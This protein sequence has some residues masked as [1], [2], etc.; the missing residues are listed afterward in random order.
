VADLEGAAHP[1]RGRHFAVARPEGRAHRLLDDE[2]QAPGGEQGFERAAIQEA[3]DAAFDH[4][5]DEA[6]D[7]ERRRHRDDERVFEQPR[8]GHVGG[9]RQF[10]DHEGH[11]GADHHH[12]AMGHVDDAH[13]AERDGEPDGGEQQHR[14]EREAEPG[15][16]RQVPYG[17]FVG[18]GGDRALGGGRD[19]GRRVAGQSL[20]QA[21]RILVAA[22]ADHRDGGELVGFLGIV[23][24]E[25]DRGARLVEHALD[26]GIG[27]LLERGLDRRQH[28]GFARLEHRLG[29][30]QALGGVG[31]HQGE[32]TQ[33]GVDRSPDPV[34]DAHGVDI[35]RPAVG[36]RRARRGVEQ[37]AGG[38]LVEDLLLLG[39]VQQ[40]VVLQRL[41]ER[42]RARIAAR[43]ERRDAFL[44]LAVV[45]QDEMRERLFEARRPQRRGR[46][47]HDDGQ[48]DGDPATPVEAAFMELHRRDF[49]QTAWRLPPNRAH[50]IT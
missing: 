9:A 5:A 12:L 25:D 15:V 42:S 45:V 29:G 41:D 30:F 37:L 2:R 14:A 44:G 17:E 24:V 27:F 48:Q 31:R 33:R 39:A 20:Q 26:A 43:R 36:D 32:A 11:I 22:G 35:G 38:I 28:I 21:D 16:L 6:R 3:D 50:I 40:A 1:G 4:D 13:D 19:G 23:G 49:P 8:I 47:Q 34:V 7:D 18:D 10:L 46:E